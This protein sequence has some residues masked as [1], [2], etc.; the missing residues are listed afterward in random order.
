MV[1][2]DSNPGLS[3]SKIGASELY[4]LWL[5]QRGGVGFGQAGVIDKGTEGHLVCL[6]RGFVQ[7]AWQRAPTSRTESG[8][9]IGSF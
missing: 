6:A 8:G 3:D 2:T 1:V 4:T 7:A 9:V 5:S